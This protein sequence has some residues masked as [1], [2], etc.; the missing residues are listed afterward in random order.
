M[1]VSQS[2]RG[3]E[4]EVLKSIGQLQFAFM[5]KLHAMLTNNNTRKA[6]KRVP[7]EGGVKEVAQFSFCLAPESMQQFAAHAIGIFEK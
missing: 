7:G 4:R 3:R 1:S 6:A 2:K 5:A